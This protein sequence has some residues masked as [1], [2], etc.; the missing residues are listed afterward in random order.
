MNGPSVSLEVLMQADRALWKAWERSTSG[1]APFVPVDVG[2][3]CYNAANAMRLALACNAIE[4][5][6]ESAKVPA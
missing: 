6:V 3:E 1:G 4:F 2:I 5:D